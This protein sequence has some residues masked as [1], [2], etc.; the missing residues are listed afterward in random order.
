LVLTAAPRCCTPSPTCSWAS[1]TGPTRQSHQLQLAAGSTLVLYTDGL[2]EHR[3]ASIDEGL[4]RLVALL[5][6]THDVDV[7]Q[8]SDLLLSSATSHGDDIALLVLR[9]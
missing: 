2:V 8:L 4:S 6:G 5:N 3:G 9:A 7:E 1:T